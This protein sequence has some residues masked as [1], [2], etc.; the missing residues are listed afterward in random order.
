MKRSLIV[1]M[2]SVVVGIAAVRGEIVSEGEVRQA[3]TAFLTEDPIGSTILKGRTIS[4]VSAK[5][6]LWIVR[7][8]P[9]G[10]IVVGGSDLLDPIVSFSVDDYIEPSENS[11]AH[12]MF[13]SADTVVKELEPICGDLARHEGWERL[14]SLPK[15]VLRLRGT[16]GS[17]SGSTSESSSNGLPEGAFTIKEPFITTQWAQWQPYNDYAPVYDPSID[18]TE[19]RGRSQSGCVAT[20]AAQMYN[21]FKWPARIDSTITCTNVFIDA[22]NIPHYFPIRFDGHVPMDWNLMLDDYP[23][24]NECHNGSASVSE[25]DLRDFLPESVRHPVARLNLWAD[26]LFNMEFRTRDSYAGYTPVN[27]SEYYTLPNN[28]IGETE[29]CSISEAISDER[30][31]HDVTNGVP[32]Q[33][34]IEGRD[35]NDPT[36]RSMHQVV[37]CGWAEYGDE[38][39]AYINFGWGSAESGKT[40]NKFYNVSGEFDVDTPDGSSYEYNTCWIL[41]GHYPRARPQID[42]LPKVCSNDVT[43]S[44]HFPDFYT[45]S[46]SGFIVTATRPSSDTTTYLD[47]FS[48]LS[49]VYKQSWFYGLGW[50]RMYIDEN[51]RFGVTRGKV[52]VTEPLAIGE[53]T[54]TNTFYL[55]SASV[56][57]FMLRSVHATTFST[58]E[59]QASFDGGDW[60]T[61]CTPNLEGMG[62]SGWRVERVFLGGHG[63][64]KV[65]FRINAAFDNNGTYWYDTMVLLDDFQVSDIIPIEQTSDVVAGNVRSF[66]LTGLIDGSDYSVT[67]TPIMSSAASSTH[68]STTMGD[69]T[70]TST[71]ATGT[72]TPLVDAETSNPISFSVA[73]DKRIYATGIETQYTTNFVFST[74]D[75]SGI[76]SYMGTAINETTVEPDLENWWTCSVTIDVPVPI[77][78]NANLDFYWKSDETNY[79]LEDEPQ[80]HNGVSYDC[81]DELYV[82]FTDADGIRT[83][84]EWKKNRE[85]MSRFQHCNFPLAQFAGKR[86]SITISCYDCGWVAQAGR[87][88][89][90]ISSAEVRRIALFRVPEVASHIQPTTAR[91]TPEIY[92]VSVRGRTI[93]EG[94]FHECDLGKTEFVVTCSD[95]VTSLEAYPSHLALV[96]DDHVTVRRL[97]AGMFKV[98]IYNTNI[99]AANENDRSRMI[100]TLVAKDDNGTEA[101]KDIS[102]RF[103]YANTRIP[104]TVFL[105]R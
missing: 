17:T 11:P 22:N 86:G 94:M 47:D 85:Q 28:W 79:N 63:G 82:Y 18:T 70:S 20:A 52:L 50:D 34:I 69:P 61:I 35:M 36:Q 41:A 64:Q 45:N 51:S 29:G 57:T 24:T 32:C 42:P 46:L 44:W 93:S 1:A 19:A 76:W 84:I 102:L 95:T 49:G 10:H 43:V 92:D 4:E 9:S 7:L 21:Y 105:L 58:Y 88:V 30:V 38:K 55:T 81:Y 13:L 72:T 89:I 97:S 33:M 40:C 100:L 3:A 48:S 15:K 77:S 99:S 60:E 53:Y 62:D 103:S 65:N 67:V 59:I 71:A 5:G 96:S 91:G 16:G 2:V 54:F 12:I 14:L 27:V 66:E 8:A 37:I 25:Y 31:V 101:Y 39:Y 23:M 56:L 90:R 83:I 87:P 68:G 6:N 74:N 73:G 26:V 75:T 78:A 80:E 104:G 98:T